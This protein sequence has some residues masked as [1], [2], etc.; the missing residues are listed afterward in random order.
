M[1]VKLNNIINYKVGYILKMFAMVAVG[2]TA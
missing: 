2:E 1:L